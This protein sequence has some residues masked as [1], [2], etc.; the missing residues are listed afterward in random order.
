[1]SL[2]SSGPKNKIQARNKYEL[3]GQGARGVGGDMFTS[4][5]RFISNGLHGVIYQKIENFI[6]TAVRTSNPYIVI[7]LL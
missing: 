2:P 5:L 4:K 6:T 1:M 3:G 7:N